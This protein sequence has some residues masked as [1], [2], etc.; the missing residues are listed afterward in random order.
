MKLLNL[1]WGQTLA[2]K[3]PAQLKQQ[4]NSTSDDSEDDTYWSANKRRHRHQQTPWKRDW[5][6]DNTT[7]VM[8]NRTTI[9]HAENHFLKKSRML[10]DLMSPVEKPESFKTVFVIGGIFLFLTISITGAVAVFCRKRNTVFALQK[11]EQEDVDDIDY[12]LD[13]F[14]DSSTEF[15]ESDCET[16]RPWLSAS[17]NHLDV[18]FHDSPVHFPLVTDRYDS[19]SED[20]WEPQGDKVHWAQVGSTVGQCKRA[21]SSYSTSLNNITNPN[22]C[23]DRGPYHQM[24][25]TAV[26][27]QNNTSTT[28]TTTASDLSPN[29]S[30][31]AADPGTADP[32]T[33][34]ATV[35]SAYCD[36]PPS[37]DSIDYAKQASNNLNN[38]ASTLPSYDDKNNTGI[39][40]MVYVDL[41][42]Y[43]DNKKVPL[44][45]GANVVY[46]DIPHD[47]HKSK[48]DNI[49]SGKYVR[50]PDSGKH[51]K[52][53]YEMLQN[54]SDTDNSQ[55]VNRS[56]G[57]CGHVICNKHKVKY[58]YCN[59]RSQYEVWR[60]RLPESQNEATKETEASGGASH[61]AI[62]Y[63][64]HQ[65]SK[66]KSHQNSHVSTRI[67][68]GSSSVKATRSSRRKTNKQQI[69]NSLHEC[70]NTT[71]NKSNQESVE[72]IIDPPTPLLP[73]TVKTL[74]QLL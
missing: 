55:D 19:D 26:M 71:D 32:G 23:D 45:D 25:V 59:E 5:M 47:H 39:E 44:E 50:L 66:H 13:E 16:P 68:D 46:V 31:T 57:K 51:N 53:S 65:N 7:A 64:V 52:Y 58:P 27:E 60:K 6:T 35:S 48:K 62:V 67:V 2:Y 40:T 8:T 4:G 29:H 36:N 38:N 14:E 33:T 22:Y 54:E 73:P 72:I 42:E 30:G 28:I 63:D 18:N 1:H 24:L 74:D 37:Y 9:R 11:S 49:N 20:K 12:E 17:R 56:H 34:D 70:N 15:E 61:H 3:V 10:T 43:E 69:N 21:S 41:P